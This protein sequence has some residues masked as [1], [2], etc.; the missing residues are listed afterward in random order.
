MA[1]DGWWLFDQ[2][3]NYLIHSLP[4]TIG[5]DGDKIY[6]GKDDL[7]AAPASRGCI[8]LAPEDAAW[9]TFWKPKNTPIIILPYTDPKLAAG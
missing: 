1:D 8:R 3:G 9:F 2:D 4:Y 7:G 5:P 6:Q